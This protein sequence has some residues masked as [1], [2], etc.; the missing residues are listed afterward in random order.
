MEK[1]AEFLDL[2]DNIQPMEQNKIELRITEKEVRQCL[3][4]MKTGKAIW[5]Q[6]YRNAYNRPNR[7]ML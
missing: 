3:E 2:A 5:T 6:K 1:K 7:Q 4:Y